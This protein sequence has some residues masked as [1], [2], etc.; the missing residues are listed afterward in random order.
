MCQTADEGVVITGRGRSHPT[1]LNS[2]MRLVRR[3]VE[4][5][6]PI[7]GLKNRAMAHLPFRGDE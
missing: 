6:N 7:R 4:A 3:L 2:T 5:V 1:W